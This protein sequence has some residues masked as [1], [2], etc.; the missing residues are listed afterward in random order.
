MLRPTAA[1][2]LDEVADFFV[3]SNDFNGVP[4][5]QL[6]KNLGLSKRDLIKQ[7]GRL[8]EDGQV[9]LAFSSVFVNPH[10]K[11]FTDLS[12]NDQLEKLASEDLSTICAYPTASV[13]QPLADMEALTGCP[14]SRRLQLA[15]PQLVPL[16]FEMAAFERYFDDPRYAVDFIDYSG[17]ISIKTE[18]YDSADTVE[19]DKVFLQ[20]FGLGYDETGSR[21][22]V[23]FPR[24][25][26]GLSADHQQ[27]W[28]SYIVDRRSY[29]IDDY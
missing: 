20:T 7:L 4:A 10:I 17:S 12:V 23:V 8:V 25:L 21:V 1:R 28:N 22:V 24:Y 9:T 14:F 11:A 18:H 26:S 15:E 29:M 19:R 2:V 16:F 3:K 5:S 6:G 13:I 27:Y